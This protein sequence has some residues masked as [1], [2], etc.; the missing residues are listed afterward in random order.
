MNIIQTKQYFEWQKCMKVNFDDKFVKNLI[1]F[2]L[3]ILMK[4]SFL[5]KYA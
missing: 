2:L 4:T 1:Q 3:I 5:G